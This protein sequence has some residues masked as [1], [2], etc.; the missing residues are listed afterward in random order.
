MA[1]EPPTVRRSEATN[2]PAIAGRELCV[3]QPDV[4][5][6]RVTKQF[7]DVKAVDELSL[8]FDRGGFVACSA[9]P[10]AVRRP[11]CG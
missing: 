8:S 6:E 11:R 7:G 3:E 10:A 2:T 1:V 9:P 4:R 5:L